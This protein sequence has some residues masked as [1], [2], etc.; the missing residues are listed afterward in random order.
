M[1]KAAIGLGLCLLFFIVALVYVPGFASTIPQS[2]L[3]RELGAPLAV[4]MSLVVLF[5]WRP[6]DLPD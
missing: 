6:A 4:I 3:V 5:S 2:D 1:L